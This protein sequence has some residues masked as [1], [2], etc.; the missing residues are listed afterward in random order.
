MSALR[1]IFSNLRW[2]LPFDKFPNIDRIPNIKC[3]TFII[4][5][6]R[7]EIVHVNHACRL[8]QACGNKEFQPY[9]V[10][11]AGHNNVERHAKDY[12]KRIR[13]FIEHID[14]NQ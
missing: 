3:P 7:D 4:H 13:E 1:V 14:L 9:F 2:T 12:L 5:G 11:M 6:L 8:W 10:E